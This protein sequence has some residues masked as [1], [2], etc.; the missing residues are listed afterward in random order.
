MAE[1]VIEEAEFNTISAAKKLLEQMNSTPE[2]RALLAKAIKI[3]HPNV[4]TEEEIAAELAAP[5]LEEVKKTRDEVKSI[6]ESLQARDKADTEARAKAD[7]DGAFSRLRAQGGYNEDGIEK[8]KALMIDRS[9]PD[10][11]AAAALFEKLNPAPVQTRSSWE[12]DKWNLESDA[13]DYD[14]KGLF[15]DPDRWENEMIGKV[16]MEER[17]KAAV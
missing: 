13:V 1:I 11:E 3:H 10:P 6:L 9:I 14:V 5:H 8:I 2:S 15:A 16:L 4:R 12:P 17:S 7:M